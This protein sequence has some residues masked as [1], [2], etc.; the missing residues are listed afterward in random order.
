MLHLKVALQVTVLN[1]AWS[2]RLYSGADLAFLI[3]GEPYS[4][5]SFQILGKCYSKEASFLQFIF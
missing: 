1:I 3:R 2:L 5:F 4:E